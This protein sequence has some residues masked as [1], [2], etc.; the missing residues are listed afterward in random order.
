MIDLDHFK[1]IN[2]TAGHAAGDAMLKAVAA[3]ITSHVRAGD[4]VVRL[5]GDEFALLL[6]RCPQDVAMR[7]AENVRSAITAITLPWENRILRV[8]ASA[9]VASLAEHTPD[10]DAWVAE[11]D[12]ACYRVKAEGRGAVRAAVPTLLRVVGG[13]AVADS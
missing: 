3:A 12:A 7:V 13:T 8:G 5:G 9:G 11:A 4:L 6:E 2:D 10:M 1:P